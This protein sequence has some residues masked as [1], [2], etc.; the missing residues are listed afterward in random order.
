[1]HRT[2]TLPSIIAKKNNNNKRMSIRNLLI[3]VECDCG[4]R[5]PILHT[6]RLFGPSNYTSPNLHP[7]PFHILATLLDFDSAHP[8][9]VLTFQTVP[10]SLRIA[11][12][13]DQS[14]VSFHSGIDDI[15]TPAVHLIS[16]NLQ[17]FLLTTS[18][19][20]N[21]PTPL[22][23]NPTSQG[24]DLCVPIKR[25]DPVCPLFRRHIFTYRKHLH[26]HTL[27][28]ATPL[29]NGSYHNLDQ[30][31]YFTATLSTKPSPA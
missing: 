23:R 21:H 11:P 5:D 30:L 9:L 25:T 20:D 22:A 7:Y 26:T 10:T 8:S 17:L 13:Q 27:H 1:M 18:P 28:T 24:E 19:N 29:P 3:F 6:V 15:T 14:L 12:E 2:L 4:E 16:E 31:L